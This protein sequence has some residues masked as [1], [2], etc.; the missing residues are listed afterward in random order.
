[1]EMRKQA[2][3]TED[4]KE[5]SDPQLQAPNTEQSTMPLQGARQVPSGTTEYFGTHAQKNPWEANPADSLL[6]DLD[7][8]ERK[9]DT[10]MDNKYEVKRTDHW[11]RS[12]TWMSENPQTRYDQLYGTSKINFEG[13]GIRRHL[14]PDAPGSEDH[15][16]RD[17]NIVTQASRLGRKHNR[18]RKNEYR[19]T[20]YYRDFVE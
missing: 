18:D 3:Y 7:L 11:A 6:Y 5:L 17:A 20:N 9:E 8:V 19:D 15:M 16:A 13:M 4:V 10:K 12:K 2:Q 1:M 14:A